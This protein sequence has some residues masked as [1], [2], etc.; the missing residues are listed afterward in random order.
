MARTWWSP[1]AHSGGCDDDA[2]GS[3]AQTAQ[4]RSEDSTPPPGTTCSF[5]ASRCRSEARPGVS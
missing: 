2:Q 4:L 5:W 3:A 1:D